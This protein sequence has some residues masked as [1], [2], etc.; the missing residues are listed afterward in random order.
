MLA[1]ARGSSIFD[2]R[3]WDT[4]FYSVG[5]GILP[6]NTHMGFR[7]LIPN[8]VNCGEKGQSKYYK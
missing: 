5:L 4:V 3:L 7:L 6:S 8:K 2:I 1:L